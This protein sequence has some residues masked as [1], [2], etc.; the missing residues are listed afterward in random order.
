MSGS[1]GSGDSCV[2]R[3]ERRWGAHRIISEGQ[4]RCLAARDG[5]DGGDVRLHFPPPPEMT[6]MG[7]GGGATPTGMAAGEDKGSYTWAPGASGAWAAP[8]PRWHE[9]GGTGFRFW[10][11][12]S[13]S[14]QGLRKGSLRLPFFLNLGTGK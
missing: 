10:T 2:S 14:K 1:A 3:G 9:G 13:I 6:R 5:L 11:D 8:P 4:S 7:C 12:V